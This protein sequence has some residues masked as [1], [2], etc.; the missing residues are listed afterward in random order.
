MKNSDRKDRIIIS[1][2][3]SLHE[4]LDWLYLHTSN[5]GPLKDPPYKVPC[6]IDGDRFMFCITD[7]LYDA[8][9]IIKSA[10]AK[11]AGLETTDF[12]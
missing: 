7:N 6:A 10:I 1:L 11:S 4:V 3:E 2:A 5:G 12:R 8:H 9:D